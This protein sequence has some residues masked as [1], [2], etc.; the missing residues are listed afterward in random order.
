M[1]AIRKAVVNALDALDIP[2]EITEHL[3]V[4]T[5]D[6]MDSLGITLNRDVVKNLFLRDPK[7]NAISWWY[8]TR[9]NGLI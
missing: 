7:E 2:Y 6:E 3:P 8:W 9:T 4:Y 1:D 5:I